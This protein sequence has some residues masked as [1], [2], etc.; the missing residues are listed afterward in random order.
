MTHSLPV[1]EDSLID[2]GRRI[3]EL[4]K[5]LANAGKGGSGIDMS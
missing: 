2:F 1:A 5:R 4:E 3:D